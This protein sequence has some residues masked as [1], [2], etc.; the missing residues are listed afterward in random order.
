MGLFALLADHSPPSG[1]GFTLP[2]KDDGPD[3][4]KDAIAGQLRLYKDLTKRWLR[5]SPAR[6]FVSW[7]YWWKYWVSGIAKRYLCE[8]FSL[9]V[10]RSYVHFFC[11]FGSLLQVSVGDAWLNTFLSNWKTTCIVPHSQCLGHVSKR[12]CMLEWKSQM[13]MQPW[14][15]VPLPIGLFIFTFYFPL[16][17]PFG[18]SSRFCCP[19]DLIPSM[20]FPSQCRW[21][22]ASP[23]AHGNGSKPLHLHRP[24]DGGELQHRHLG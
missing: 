11:W 6:V 22:G 5:K 2:R 14:L 7:L 21:L 15:F 12:H 24:I 4:E 9:V 3:A 10:D 16:Y 23:A 20:H 19:F 13:L 18:R 1:G 8:K 17:V